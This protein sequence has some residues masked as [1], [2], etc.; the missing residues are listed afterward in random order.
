MVF[1]QKKKAKA[2]P[3]FQ[4]I[5]S[6]A[7]SSKVDVGALAPPAADYLAGIT[8]LQAA[9]VTMLAASAQDAW[10]TQDADALMSASGRAMDRY[11]AFHAVLFDY[12][13]DVPVALAPARESLSAHMSRFG[14]QRWHEQVTTCYVV[15]GFTRDFW[16]LLADGLPATLRTKCQQILSDQGDE[17]QMAGVLARLLESDDRYRSTVSLWSRRLVGDVMLLCRGALSARARASTDTEV[18]L[19]PVFTEVV[20]HHTRRLDRVGLTA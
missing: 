5:T 6:G 1:W 3:S 20:A 9:L 4:K 16:H 18:P 7:L 14:T 10:S 12:V 13:D 17:E 11:R 15:T 19:E 2:K 8:S